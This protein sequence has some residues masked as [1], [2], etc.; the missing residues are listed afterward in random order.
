MEPILID[1]SVT[2]LENLPNDILY[3]IFEYLDYSYLFETFPCL[4]K[5]FH[6]LIVDSNLPINVNFSIMS[7]SIFE[8]YIR[9]GIQSNYFIKNFK[10]NHVRFCIFLDWFVIKIESNKNAYF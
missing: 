3:E 8:C 2:L 7:K 1:E 4:N 5:R 9:N 6:S 10:Y